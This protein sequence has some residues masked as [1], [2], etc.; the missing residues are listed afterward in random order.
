MVRERGFL[1]LK[2]MPRLALGESYTTF[3]KNFAIFAPHKKNIC[4]YRENL[5]F[6][7][8]NCFC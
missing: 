7:V 1:V 5:Y 6:F 3:I 4:K 8:I 2:G